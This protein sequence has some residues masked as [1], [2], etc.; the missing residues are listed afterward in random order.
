MK[1]NIEQSELLYEIAEIHLNWLHKYNKDSETTFEEILEINHNKLLTYFSGIKPIE[2][3]INEKL[4][5]MRA[6]VLRLKYEY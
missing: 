4:F 6:R 5:E 1:L 2:K 3:Q